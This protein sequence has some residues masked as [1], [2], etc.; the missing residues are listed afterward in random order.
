[1]TVL[2][3]AHICEGAAIAPGS[4][5]TPR[6]TVGMGEVWAGIPARKIRDLTAAEKAEIQQ[7]CTVLNEVR[8]RV[9]LHR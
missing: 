8:L 3:G 9:P 2:D 5:V 1:M 7:M 4:V 6:K